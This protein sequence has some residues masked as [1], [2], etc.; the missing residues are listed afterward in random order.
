M[1][2]LSETLVLGGE[3]RTAGHHL[4]PGLA[5]A[6]DQGRRRLALD[7]H[8]ADHGQVGPGEVFPSQ[9]G[10]IGVDEAQGPVLGQHRGYGDQSQRLV[11]GLLAHEGEG[12]LE[13]PKGVGKPRV[14]QQNVHGNLP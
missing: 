14:D 11:A 7:V 9:V 3:E 10:D 8:R 12:V 13:A 4:D 2:D 6:A 5:A 1:V